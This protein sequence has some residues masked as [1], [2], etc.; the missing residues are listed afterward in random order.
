M[1]QTNATT[2][3][4]LRIVTDMFKIYQVMWPQCPKPEIE[5]DILNVPVKRH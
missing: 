5:Q 3:S 4:Q 1:H 2:M